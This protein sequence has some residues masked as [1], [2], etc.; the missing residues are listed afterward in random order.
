MTWKSQI[1]D[2]ALWRVLDQVQ[3]W[4]EGDSWPEGVEFEDLER[5]VVSVVKY[6]KDR[7][8]SALVYRVSRGALD[9][10]LNQANAVLQA[11]QQVTSTPSE[12][13]LA[14]AHTQLDALLD[15]AAPLPG[16]ST[17]K[18]VQGAEAAAS[19]LEEHVTEEIQ[20]VRT[21]AGEIR[22]QVEAYGTEA[23]K[24]SEQLKDLRQQVK[25]TV[26]T[27]ASVFDTAELQRDK[28]AS[29]AVQRYV[30]RADEKC[31]KLEEMHAE[32]EDLLRK[33]AGGA[34]TS[35]YDA[36]AKKQGRAAL[37]WSVLTVVLGVA[38][39]V[40]LV[41]AL[42]GFSNEAA[43][44]WSLVSLK[45]VAGLTV[46]GVAAYTGREAAGHR[47]E[48]RTATRRAIAMSVFEPFVA[49]ADDDD[50][51]RLRVQIMKELFYDPAVT[52][53]ADRELQ[54]EQSS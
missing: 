3:E 4:V 9:R 29:D 30:E 46:A 11:V 5:R 37:C 18:A 31:L 26:D 40:L 32:A 1:E 15:L 13:Q 44:A 33:I 19:K 53:T 2:H 27:Q 16:L 34:T 21:A 12:Q 41:I 43:P 20:R 49:N 52:S 8:S 42:S 47:A 38:A 24:T 17:S 28:D 48:Q 22:A 45:A 51:K 7:K 10:A 39:G 23:T 35:Y 14:A 25:T 36:Y 6:L 50:T 54:G